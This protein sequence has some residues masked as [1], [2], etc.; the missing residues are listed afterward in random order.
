MTKSTSENSSGAVTGP[1]VSVS[2]FTT[3]P[4]WLAVLGASLALYALTASRTVQWQDQGQFVLRV[5]RDEITDPY[6]LALAHPLHFWI[7]RASVRVLPFEPPFAVA[8][9]SSLFAAICVANVFGLVRQLTESKLPA[10]L[11]AGGLAL[12]HTF[13]H[14][15]SVVEVYSISAAFLTAE[16]WALVNWDGTRRAKW[17]VLMF[18]ANGLG[19]ANHNL[20]LL[21]L[22]VD[23][24]VLLSALFRRQVKWRVLLL[25]GAVWLAG[26]S[27]L[28]G[29]VIQQ[30]WVNG[31]PGEVLHS[32]LF[33]RYQNQVLAHAPILRY[34]ATSLAFTLLSFPNVMLPAALVGIVRGR[35]LVAPL[36]YWS[37]LTALAIHLAFVLRYNVIDQYTFMVPAYALIAV[38][39]GVGIH[40]VLERLRPAWRGVGVGLGVA[41]VLLTPAWYLLSEHL[42]RRIHALGSYERHKPYRDDYRYL[43]IPWGRGENSADRM[44]R[45]AAELAGTDGLIIVEDEMGSFAVNYQLHRKRASDVRVIETTDPSLIARYSSARR[46]VV[47]VPSAT[48][49]PPDK[50]PVGAWRPVGDLYVL[51]PP[52][53]G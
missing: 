7:C 25:C 12:A 16:M 38:F 4:F 3:W 22:P 11:A 33:G 39:A 23:G 18:L 10:L 52:L 13:W 30:A 46:P 48:T 45:Q 53:G 24:I 40:L 14:M 36:S 1:S 27:P 37:L 15:G 5:V 19:L 8:L 49:R 29:L 21:T 35:R 32:A 6:G 31:Q 43:F 42:T 34:T 26:A 9:V 2:D 28:I 44:S 47:L 50:P 17:L 41:T 20:A 51:V